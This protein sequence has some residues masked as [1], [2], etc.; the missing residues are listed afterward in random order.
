MTIK[1]LTIQ[2]ET[3]ISDH[4]NEFVSLSNKVKKIGAELEEA[5][6]NMYKIVQELQPVEYLIRNQNPQMTAIFD[7]LKEDYSNKNK[8]QGA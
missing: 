7:L 4:L 6:H 3:R 8:E 5:Q 1:E 2:L